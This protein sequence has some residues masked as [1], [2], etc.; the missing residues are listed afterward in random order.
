MSGLDHIDID[1]ILQKDTSPEGE[2]QRDID[3]KTKFENADNDSK[4]MCD[5]ENKNIAVIL[6]TKM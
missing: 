5:N 4:E 6:E 1:I 2:V 3:T